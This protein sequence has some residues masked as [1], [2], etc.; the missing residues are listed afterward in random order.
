L[1]PTLPRILAYW[2]TDR[3]RPATIT[4]LKKALRI[5]A[6]HSERLKELLGRMVEQSVL[7][8]KG[9]RFLLAPSHQSGEPGQGKRRPGT[10]PNPKSTASKGAASRGTPSKGA[11]SKSAASKGTASRGTASK[12]T[13]S[14]STASKNTVSKS[15]AKRPSLTDPK[16]GHGK[17][18][19]SQEAPPLPETETFLEGT[20][21]AHPSGFGFVAVPGRQEDVFIPPRYIVGA[22]DGDRVRV[23]ILPLKGKMRPAWKITEVLERRRTLIRGMVHRDGGQYWLAPLN[24]RIPYIFLAPE[25]VHQH[26]ASL[27]LTDGVFAEAEIVAYPDLRDEAPEG[28]LVRWLGKGEPEPAELVDHILGDLQW[29]TAF[30]EATKAEMRALERG[31]PPSLKGRKDLRE[32]LFVTIDGEDA[33]DFDDAVCLES[34]PG[35]KQRLSVAIADVAA[36]V[37]PGTAVDDDAYARS[38]SVYFPRRVVPMLPQRLSN[39]L[40]SLKP[41]VPRLTMTCEMIFDKKWERVDYRIVD[42]VIE[43]KARLTYKQVLHAFETGKLKG[44]E[45]ERGGEIAAMLDRMRIMAAKMRNG[46][47]ARGA[48]D[49]TFPEARVELDKKGRPKRLV[50]TFPTE[51]TQLIEQFMLEANETVAA[52]CERNNLPVPYRVHDPPPPEQLPALA[53]VLWNLGLPGKIKD[54]HEPRAVAELLRSIK[55]HPRQNQAELAI[56]KAMSQAR[57]RETNDG[58]FALAAEH[59]AHFTSPIRRYPD[60]LV[61]RAL[62]TVLRGKPVTG[63]LAADTAFWISGRE[64]TASEAE[65]RVIRMYKVVYME[66]RV[67]EIF[68]ATVSGVAESGVFVRLMEE[69]VE[70]M[71][72]ARSLPG[73]RP[74]L[75]TSRQRLELGGRHKS[76]QFGDPLRVRLAAADRFAQRLDLEFIGFGWENPS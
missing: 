59:Y 65:N 50:E 17:K 23:E 14:K 1:K 24:E 18:G 27:A 53:A 32:R 2:H 34:L 54:L 72:P 6:A 49:F 10:P 47:A 37:R 62:K 56:L 7:I 60:L 3:E 9:H 29:P 5:P 45:G 58:H 41:G 35:G 33:K 19:R 43:S 46:R 39:D 4:E 64:R 55:G 8:R 75:D 22:L 74:R 68:E 66:P 61:H 71:I 70:G 73:G 16:S 48:L 12:S 38:T 76:L 67:G 42:S 26:D 52:H 21:T 51:S 40:C 63:T 36:F 20:F 31:A 11:V 28:R 15:A 57:Y 13:A 69:P 44:V 25:D 30:S